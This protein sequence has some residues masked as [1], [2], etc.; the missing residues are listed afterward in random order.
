VVRARALAPR[1]RV[2]ADKA[3]PDTNKSLDLHLR[4]K[5]NATYMRN[6]GSDTCSVQ[7][8]D[9]RRQYGRRE[10]DDGEVDR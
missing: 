3:G 5:L 1:D 9:L 8:S 7:P 2:T 6:S 4:L 10:R